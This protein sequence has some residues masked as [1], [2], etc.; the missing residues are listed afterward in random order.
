MPPECAAVV[1]LTPP[2]TWEDNVDAAAAVAGIV[3]GEAVVVAACARCNPWCCNRAP[4]L[5]VRNGVSTYSFPSRSVSGLGAASV[6]G[7][8]DVASTVACTILLLGVRDDIVGI[9]VPGGGGR[10]REKLVLVCNEDNGR[11]IGACVNTAA[12]IDAD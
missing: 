11:V 2:T 1:P 12:A 9:V 7:D 8:M 10:R 6:T 4:S 5:G 3:V